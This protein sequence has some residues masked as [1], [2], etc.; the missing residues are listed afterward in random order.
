MSMDTQNHDSLPSMRSLGNLSR[1]DLTVGVSYFTCQLQNLSPVSSLTPL[2]GLNCLNIQSSS[3]LQEITSL[4][5][6]KLR[7]SDIDS[8][9]YLLLD[10]SGK[11]RPFFVVVVCLFPLK[12]K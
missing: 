6:P 2:C 5:F 3:Q 1:A 8:R 7:G 11:K 12:C 10:Y 9:S 4:W